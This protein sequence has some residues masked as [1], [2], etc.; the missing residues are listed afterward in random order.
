VGGIYGIDA[1]TDGGGVQAKLW[2]MR[3]SVPLYFLAAHESKVRCGGRERERERERA[4]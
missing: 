1:E 4:Y 2:D 3:A